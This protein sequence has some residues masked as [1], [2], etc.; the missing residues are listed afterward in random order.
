MN[1]KPLVSVIT[2]FLDGEAF[3]REAIESV[4]AQTY[5]HWELLLI[6]DGSAATATAIARHYAD[7]RPGKVR[8]LEH[9]GHENRGVCASRN[10]GVRHARGEYV[11]LLDA[12]D[13]WLPHKLERQVAI[14]GAQP[15]AAMVYGRSE[16]WHSWTGNAEDICRDH[17]PELGVPT[18]TL[19]RPPTLLKATSP[20]GQAITPC[21]SDLM[22]RRDMIERVG[23]FEESFRGIYQLYEDRAFL[24]KVYLREPV[25]VA[26]ECWDRYRQH[27]DSCVAV[28]NKARQQ[29][30][31]RLVFLTWLEGYLSRQGVTDAELRTALRRVLWPYRHPTLQRVRGRARR[32]ATRVK[33]LLQRALASH[34]R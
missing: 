21:P 19:V 34:A 1:P 33:E 9:D 28:V 13:V 6:D 15:E 18:D 22:F 23:G 8:Y 17:V 24:A 29:Q 30:S 27:P 25:F 10:L 5:D 16:Y 11:A 14:L 4:M 7:G 2:P 20:L 26:N 31:V 3:L 12:D 32:Y